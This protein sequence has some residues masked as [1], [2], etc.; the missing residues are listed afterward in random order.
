[1]DKQNILSQGQ[2][3]IDSTQNLSAQNQLSQKDLDPNLKQDQKSSP[4]I[5]KENQNKVTNNQIKESSQNVNYL[6]M[7]DIEEIQKKQNSQSDQEGF[8]KNTKTHL[9]SQ[10][11]NTESEN[12]IN[13]SNMKKKEEDL[14][15]FPFSLHSDLTLK[16]KMQSLFN[17][18]LVQKEWFKNPVIQICNFKESQNAIITYQN[19]ENKICNQYLSTTPNLSD[20][21]RQQKSNDQN[22]QTQTVRKGKQKIPYLIKPEGDLS[23]QGKIIQNIHIEEISNDILL[24]S[25]QDQSKKENSYDV[26]QQNYNS[27]YQSLKNGS[28]ANIEKMDIF[29]YSLT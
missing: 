17:R 13:L 5:I 18:N 27:I 28:D 9:I 2:Q 23:N 4:S 19:K 8:A 6:S 21:S 12:Q 29:N 1:M 11:I 10:T 14:N 25:V 20:I 3:V 26:Q 22:L 7:Q 15:I 24:P 16:K